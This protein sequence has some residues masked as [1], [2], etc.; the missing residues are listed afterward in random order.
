ILPLMSKMIP[1]LKG[2][3]SEEKYWI[4]CWTLSSH[5]WKF[6]FERP[7]TWWFP[8]SVTVVLSSTRSTSML[9]VGEPWLLEEALAALSSPLCPKD[10]AHISPTNSAILAQAI[11]SPCCVIGSGSAPQKELQGVFQSSQ[12][13]LR[14]SPSGI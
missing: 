5:T 1:T 10:S 11:T 14:T 6:S 2:R 3:S 4:S 9:N 7:A 13:K 8:G 12:L